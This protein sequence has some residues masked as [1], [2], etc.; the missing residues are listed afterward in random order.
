MRKIIS[1]NKWGFALCDDGTLWKLM[2]KP[3]PDKQEKDGS[4]I[5]DRW[6]KEVPNVPQD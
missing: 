6:W 4:F 5:I 3:Q 1:F 2:E